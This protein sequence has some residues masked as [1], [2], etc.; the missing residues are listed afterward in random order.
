MPTEPAIK[1]T[2]PIG[3]PSPARRQGEP[4]SHFQATSAWGVFDHVPLESAYFWAREWLEG[5]R[6]AD[7]DIRAG[8]VTRFDDP[9]EGIQYLW[10][11][12]RAE[13]EA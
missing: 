9:D 6:E 4:V 7:E 1:F 13:E 11:L 5:E 8:R 10:D 12:L 2:S 3:F